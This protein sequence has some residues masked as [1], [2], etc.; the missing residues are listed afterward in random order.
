MLE[1]LIDPVRL[2]YFLPSAPVPV[3]SR[4]AGRE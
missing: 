3:S 1:I 2:K 4:A